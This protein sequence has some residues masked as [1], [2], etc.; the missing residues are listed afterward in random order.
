LFPSGT[1][2]LKISSLGG[3]MNVSELAW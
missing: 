1:K 2:S 3:V